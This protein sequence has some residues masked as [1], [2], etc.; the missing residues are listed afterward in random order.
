MEQQL[1]YGVNFCTED[2]TRLILLG[3]LCA[4]WFFPGC[5]FILLW[6]PVFTE[7]TFGAKPSNDL[8]VPGAAAAAGPGPVGL[9]RAGEGWGPWAQN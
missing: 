1:F 2:F 8:R 3:S 7:G 4:K 9:G 6:R 5:C